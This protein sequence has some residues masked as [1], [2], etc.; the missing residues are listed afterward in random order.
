MHLFHAIL[1]ASA[2]LLPAAVSAVG[3]QACY[4]SNFRDCTTITGGSGQCL[5]VGAPYNDHVYSARAISGTSRC[6]SYKHVNNGA[7]SELLVA[8]IDQAG[9]SGLPEGDDTSA[10]VCYN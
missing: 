10:F 6:D 7:C 1:S 8:G 3:I 5:Y 4:S 9:Y 2:F